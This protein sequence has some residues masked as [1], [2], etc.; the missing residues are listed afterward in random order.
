MRRIALLA[1]LAPLAGAAHAQTSV[2]LA[3]AID[4]GIRYTNSKAGSAFSMNSNGL[5]TSNRLDFVGREDLGGGYDVHFQLESGFNLGSGALDNT[6]GVLFNRGAY[7]GM[8]GWFGTVNLGRQY[9]VA[10]DI[11][12]DYDPFN[13]SYPSITPVTPA[14]DGF[15]FN[16]D[17]K[18]IGSYGPVNFR[19]ENSFG[20][21]A[22]D[23][24]AGAARGVG[25]QYKSG[26]LNVGGVYE[27]RTVQVNNVYQPDN[28]VAFGAELVFGSLRFAGG[29]MNENQNSAEPAADVRTLNY[30]GGV[31]YDVNPFMRLG[32][33]Y[34][35][36]D[37][38]NSGG[39]RSQG[40]VSMTYS[41]SKRTRLYA[42][43]D[44]TK[45]SGS[46][47]TNKTLNPNNIPHQTAFS[48]GMN[49]LF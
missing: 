19:A 41:L 45:F 47:V 48:V 29:Y 5:F 44:Y 16:N 38:P 6:S 40:I 28:Y 42:E 32:G 36:T 21:V 26:W 18:Y 9:T 12:Y 33:A 27:Y 7:I 46:Y 14:T 17:V 3:G 35:I 39:K 1:A 4:G 23:F 8:S 10:H 49:H 20:G 15:R 43:A 30:W 11:I 25:L 24:N 13:F 22:G 34:Y 37:L 2:T 31:T